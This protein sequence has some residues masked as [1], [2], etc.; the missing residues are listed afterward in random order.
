LG[1][2]TRRFSGRPGWD[3]LGWDTLFER[4]PLSASVRQLIALA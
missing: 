2:V 4:A 1:N 3:L